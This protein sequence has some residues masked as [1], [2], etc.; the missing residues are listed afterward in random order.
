MSDTNA[1]LELMRRVRAGD[2]QAAEDLVRQ[3]E[4]AIRLEI[5]CRLRDPRLRRVFETADIC[6]AVL[7]SFFV[8]AASGQYDL[9]TPQQLLQLLKVM[10]QKKLAHHARS[11]RA[12]RRDIARVEAGGA[13]EWNLPDSEPTPSRVLAGK[14]LLG[15]VRERL[16]PEERQV[17]DLRGQGLEW[18]AI[19][20]QLGGTPVARRKQLSR[21]LDRVAQELGLDESDP[22]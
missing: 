14:E 12:Q 20:E 1:F 15:Q 6:Q 4:P 7:G 11:Q 16:S 3:Y 17:A 10:A 8:R 21:A 22:E 19:A 18:K 5:H 13:E 9:D 2:A